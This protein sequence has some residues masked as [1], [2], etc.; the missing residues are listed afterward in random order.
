MSTQNKNKK[1]TAGDMQVNSYGIFGAESWNALIFFYTHQI[2]ETSRFSSN[3]RLFKGT[4]NLPENRCE[5]NRRHYPIPWEWDLKIFF[6]SVYLELLIPKNTR[7]DVSRTHFLGN[8]HFWG[9]NLDLRKIC[10]YGRGKNWS[11]SDSVLKITQE[12]ANKY[13]VF[14]KGRPTF[15]RGLRPKE[16]RRYRC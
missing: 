3:R 11:F 15:N 14:L 7:F 9:E 2:A 5:T 10:G 6:A 12:L 4:Y 8:S 1:N 16:E 13:S